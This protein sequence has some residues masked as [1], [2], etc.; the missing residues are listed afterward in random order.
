M[1]WDDELC[2]NTIRFDPVKYDEARLRSTVRLLFSPM[3]FQPP[4]ASLPTDPKS[5]AKLDIEESNR[6]CGKTLELVRNI[7]LLP[8]KGV[9]DYRNAEIAGVKDWC[10]FESAKIRGFGNPAALREYQP[11]AAACSS[12]VDALEGRTDIMTTFRE[13]VRQV[14][15]RNASPASCAADFTGQS[16]R[17]DG[18]DW[19]RLQVTSFGWNNCADK[20]AI[21]N[22]DSQKLE[23][24][25]TQL[26]GQFKRLFKITKDHCDSP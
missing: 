18:K 19:I 22:A 15:S 7:Q 9:E 24:M 4:I 5:V 17:P 12:F 2:R 26:V 1:S 25:R 14:C 6:E 23:Q 8:L 16:Q 11:A 3:D 13:M 10:D 20:L 21:L